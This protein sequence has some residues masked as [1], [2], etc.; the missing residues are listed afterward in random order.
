M[1]K[2]QLKAFEQL[3]IVYEHQLKLYEK[4]MQ[5]ALKGI[6]LIGKATCYNSNQKMKL[7][8]RWEKRIQRLENKMKLFPNN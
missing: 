7:V 8:E 1:L 3:A 4:A 5:Y 6:D 2:K